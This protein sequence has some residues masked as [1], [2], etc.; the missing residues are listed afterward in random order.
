MKFSKQITPVKIAVG[1]TVL[2]AI[3][4]LIGEKDSALDEAPAAQQKPV[5]SLAKVEFTNSRAEPWQN[6][7]VVQ[8]QIEPWQQVTVTAQVSG[9]IAK[10]LKYQGDSVR[11][12]E[13]LLQLSDEGRS[14]RVAQA[15]ADVKLRELE[16]DSAVQ[17]KKSKFV[18]E[19]E[20]SR[21][22]SAL[23]EA[24]ANLVANQ[25]AVQYSKP[26]APFDGVI[27][28]RHVEPGQLVNNG[29]ALMDVV[30]VS[31]LKVTAY[32]PQQK[33]SE[34]AVGESVQLE[35][36]DGRT[37]EGKIS[38]VSFAAEAQTRS[39]Y[40]EVVTPNPR[41]WRV[42]GASVTLRIKLPEVAAHRFS[43]ALLSLNAKG[44]LGVDTVDAD[45]KVQFY[46]VQILRVDTQEAAVRGLP[47]SVR[48]ITLGAGFV[49]QGQLVEPVEASQ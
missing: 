5:E 8:G 21:F 17:L 35:L 6:E 23:A 49:E 16:L 2:L 3:W 12:G 26:G 38:F 37:T 18:A 19:T 34:L 14:E 31:Q 28:R 40:I 15:L 1:L 33:V 43:P 44:Q 13:A 30:D 7:V 48:L 22:K 10:V 32:I 46:P 29:T 20:I 4:L 24:K 11:E 45:N 27:N 9:R 41:G 36:L 47:E 42:A 25:L 39:Y